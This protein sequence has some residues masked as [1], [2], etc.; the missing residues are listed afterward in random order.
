MKKNP[1]S[2]CIAAWRRLLTVH[3]RVI[4]RIEDKLAAAGLPP[5]GWYDVLF[6]LHEQ[7]GKRLRMAALAEEVLLSRSGLTR[8]VDRLE[9][10]GHLRREPCATDKRGF[11]V[12]LTE[13][14]TE[15]MKQIWPV[16]RAGIAEHF[17]GPLS[18][19]DVANLSSAFGKILLPS[20]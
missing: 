19:T 14:G 13:S 7:P 17:S 10:K 11:L 16:Y 18:D 20:P 2:E 9:A 1:S 6:A 5:L 12:V 8:L 15:V 4:A 3:A